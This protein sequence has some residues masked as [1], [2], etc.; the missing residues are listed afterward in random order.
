MYV[1]ISANRGLLAGTH[2]TYSF[3]MIPLHMPELT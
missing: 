3:V 1:Y 2:L